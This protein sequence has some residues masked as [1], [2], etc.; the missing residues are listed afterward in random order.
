MLVL[1]K[2]LEVHWDMFP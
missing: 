1:R 2:A